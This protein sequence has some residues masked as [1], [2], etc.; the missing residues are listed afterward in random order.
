MM[1]EYGKRV[2]IVD[3]EETVRR[4]LIEQLIPHRLIVLAVADGLQ[5]LRALHDRPFNAVIT[6][7]HL[8]YLDGL[9]L[10]RQC[11][12]VWPQ[13]PVILM[14]GCLSVDIVELA[15]T[16]GAT[17]CLSKPVDPDKLIHV[18]SEAISE[19]IE[20]D[21]IAHMLKAQRQCSLS[22]ETVDNR[23]SD[24]YREYKARR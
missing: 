17:A 15:M 14:S 9:D 13:L 4:F 8:P 6:D 7:L 5:A 21:M 22:V 23:R 24:G 12:L 20:A 16:Q 1:L 3:N 19:S 2:L 11:R 18:L 10:L